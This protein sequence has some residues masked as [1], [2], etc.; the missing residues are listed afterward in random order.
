MAIPRPNES[1]RALHL[2]GIVEQTDAEQLVAW[3]LP[4]KSD[5]ALFGQIIHIYSA[6]DFM[7]RFT[8]EMMDEQ[9]LLSKSWKGKIAAENISVVSREVQSNKMWHESHRVAFERIEL[10]RRIRNMLA[11]FLIRRFQEEDAFV[12]MTKSAADF[13]QVFGDLPAMEDMLYGVTDADQIRI[14]V[15]ELRALSKWLGTLPHSLSRP[16][17]APDLNKV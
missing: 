3:P 13:R 4:T 16:I 8:A 9:G 2:R 10:H 12:F 1:P 7:L 17:P 14:L 5:F 11:H 6:V 15:P